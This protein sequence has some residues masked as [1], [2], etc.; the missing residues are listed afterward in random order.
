MP[1]FL[2]QLAKYEARFLN[3][4]FNGVESKRPTF[5]LS[6]NNE[7][8]RVVA[9]GVAEDDDLIEVYCLSLTLSR[10]IMS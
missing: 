9:L 6:Q 7:I 8:N 10:C 2:D 4:M 5:A 1:L 3:G